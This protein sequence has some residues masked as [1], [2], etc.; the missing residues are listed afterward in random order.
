MSI[1]VG[2]AAVV[3]RSVILKKIRYMGLDATM[4]VLVNIGLRS[5]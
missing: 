2:K 5:K 3:L 1:V 4:F